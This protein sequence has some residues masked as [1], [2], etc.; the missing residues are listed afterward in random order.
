VETAARLAAAQIDTAD[1]ALAAGARVVAQ[2]H[3]P[4]AEVSA[5]AVVVVAAEAAAV[6]VAVV[7]AAAEAADADKGLSSYG[8]IQRCG[9]EIRSGT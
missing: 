5:A 2:V 4:V 1:Q 3:A 7:A 8:K 9:N 6:V